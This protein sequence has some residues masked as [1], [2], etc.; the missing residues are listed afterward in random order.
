METIDV[1][2]YLKAEWKGSNTDAAFIKG[3]NGVQLVSSGYTLATKFCT[4]DEFNE[5][6]N[7]CTNNHT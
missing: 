2:N 3:A 7:N 5:C 4:Y 1:V 6:V